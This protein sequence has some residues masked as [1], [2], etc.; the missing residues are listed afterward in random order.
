MA[1]T[2]HPHYQELDIMNVDT[3]REK[4]DVNV[5]A[6][7]WTVIITVGISAVSF[8]AIWYMFR[9]LE[10]RQRAEVTAATPLT[11]MQRPA[12][13][14]VPKEQPLLQ[15]FQ[16]RAEDLPPY[17]DTPVI[18]L[19]KMRMNEETALSS[20]AWIDQQKGT[21]RIPLEEAKKIALQ[22]GFPVQPPEGRPEAGTTRGTP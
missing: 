6:L 3:H 7:I 12:D 17:A 11:S 1:D 19:Q 5:R 21:V 10:S 20:Y 15:P 2:K 8:V 9:I 22:K 13:M 16:R 4:S 18:D 14:S